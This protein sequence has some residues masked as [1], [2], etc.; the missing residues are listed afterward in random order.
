VEFIV[1]ENFYLS[2]S[3]GGAKPPAP[4]GLSFCH[5]DSILAITKTTRLQ[6]A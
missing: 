3:N 2:L 4:A 6:K 1:I 5:T